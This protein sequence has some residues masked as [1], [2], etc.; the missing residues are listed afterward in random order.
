MIYEPGFFRGKPG[1]ER[2]CILKQENTEMLSDLLGVA[3]IQYDP[4]GQWKYDLAK[5][6]QLLGYDVD[7]NDVNCLRIPP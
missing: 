5:E 7:A 4:H 3:T 6:L 2:V 1:M